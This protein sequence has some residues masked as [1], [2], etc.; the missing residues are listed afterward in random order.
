MTERVGRPA[1]LWIM[2]GFLLVFDLVPVMIFLASSQALEV[3]WVGCVI[4]IP[5]WVMWMIW[6]GT[7]LYVD[8][9]G[10][11]VPNWLHRIE[12][13]WHDVD[14]VVIEHGLTFKVR[15]G[16]ER[17][18][19]KSTHFDASN[20]GELTGYRSHRSAA[21]LL[22]SRRVAAQE[23]N[24]ASRREFQDRRR[25]PWRS[26]LMTLLIIEAAAIALRPIVFALLHAIITVLVVVFDA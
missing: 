22:E 2:V 8:Q 5:N 21:T 19:V 15:V 24:S 17:I 4:A 13:S 12:F 11:V 6:R 10:V 18:D 14:E 25:I 26:F 16:G 23:F 7:R 1:S 9:Q 3:L 20:L